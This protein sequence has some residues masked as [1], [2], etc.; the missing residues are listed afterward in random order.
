MHGDSVITSLV[1]LIYC[2]QIAPPPATRRI[3]LRCGGCSGLACEAFYRLAGARLEH[4]RAEGGG[5]TTPWRPSVMARD[6]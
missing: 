3:F 5:N 4:T 6:N 2:F 1:S